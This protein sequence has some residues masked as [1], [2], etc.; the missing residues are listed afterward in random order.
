MKESWLFKVVPL[1]I[2]F[3]FLVI[4]TFWIT[5]GVL[6]FKGAKEIQGKGLKGFIELVWNGDGVKKGEANGRQ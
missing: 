1:F 5:C 6:V 3:V 4:V 2:G